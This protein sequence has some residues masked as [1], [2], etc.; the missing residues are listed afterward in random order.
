MRRD[1]NTNLIS[2]GLTAALTSYS[3]ARSRMVLRVTAPSSREQLDDLLRR[4]GG[5]GLPPNAGHRR[6][7]SALGLG[8]RRRRGSVHSRGAVGLLQIAAGRQR[9]ARSTLIDGV[10]FPAD[11]ALERDGFEPSVP[12]KRQP[13]LL[14]PFGPAIRF[15]QLKIGS[16]V[17][18]TDGSNPSPSTGESAANLTRRSAS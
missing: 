8:H 5:V 3:A 16:F 4:S 14:P 17:P 15:R 9:R 2:L 1:E 13:F 7:G 10:K 12:H 18:G 6:S 11:S